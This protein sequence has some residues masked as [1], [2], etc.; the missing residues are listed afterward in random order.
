MIVTADH[1]ELLGE[2]GWEHGNHLYLPL[3]HVPLVIRAPARVRA[4]VRV[5][6]TVSLRDVAATLMDL[7]DSG[8]ATASP[9]PGR[10]LRATWE[11]NKAEEV[12]S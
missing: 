11:E 5:R 4:G 7:V 9:L 1:G 10:S 3:I 12:S 8:S 2:H 6:R